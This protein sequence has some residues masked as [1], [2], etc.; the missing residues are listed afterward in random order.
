MRATIEA[1]GVRHTGVNGELLLRPDRT[2]DVALTAQGPGRSDVS[3][4]LLLE[5]FD[6]PALDLTFDFD[7]FQ[8]VR[9]ADRAGSSWSSIL[10]PQRTRA[11]VAPRPG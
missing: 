1:I 4:T 3:G 5:P 10:A 7:R 2:V 8:A 6:N 9:R 11:A